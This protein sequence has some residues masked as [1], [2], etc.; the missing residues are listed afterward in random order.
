M[1][2][3]LLIL[4]FF[5]LVGCYTKRGAVRRFC[6]TEYYQHDS[7]VYNYKDSTLRKTVIHDSTILHPATQQEFN[8]GN[9]CDSLGFL[10]SFYIKSKVGGN[11]ISIKSDGKSLVVTANTDSIIQHLRD[12]NDSLV[13]HSVANNVE[14]HDVTKTVVLPPEPWYKIVPHWL[15]WW[16]LISSGFFVWHGFKFLKPLILKIPL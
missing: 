15:W 14:F 16:L 12:V 3:L 5:I 1:K 9:P 7:T 8:L 6:K 2:N 4:C 11:S 13:K 10:R